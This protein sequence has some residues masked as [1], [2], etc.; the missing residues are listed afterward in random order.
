MIIGF[1][2]ETGSK[3]QNHSENALKNNYAS[4]YFLRSFRTENIS[5]R[6]CDR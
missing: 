4:V 1:T 6:I 5:N 3:I 2:F